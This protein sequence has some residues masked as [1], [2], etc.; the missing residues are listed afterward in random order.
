MGSNGMFDVGNVNVA[1]PYF[2]SGRS[3]VL[4][5]IAAAGPVARLAQLGMVDPRDPAAIVPTPIRISQIRM[6]LAPQSSPTA[7]ATFEILKGTG[8]PATTGGN[9]HAA[10]RRKTSYQAISLAETHLYVAD[11]GVI[12]GG[13]FTPLDAT[14]PLDWVSLGMVDVSS[15]GSVWFPW[16]LCGLTLEAGEA[17]EVRASALSTGTSLLLFAAD[18]L[19]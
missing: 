18:F 1:A 3:G 5:A 12:S 11:T 15:S 4:G 19:R 9:A 14:G 6:K 13:A 2:I 17:L 10:Q 16:D 7:G 8:T